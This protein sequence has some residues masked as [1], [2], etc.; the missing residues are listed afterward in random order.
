[1][2]VVLQ[3]SIREEAKALPILLRHSPAVILRD[4]V[5]VVSEAAAKALRK[6]GVRFAEVSRENPMAG[7][8]RAQRI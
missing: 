6:A 1:M 2:K 7:V 5:Y 3:F 8:A 4:R